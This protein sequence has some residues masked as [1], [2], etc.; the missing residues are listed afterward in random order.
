MEESV[1][2]YENPAN[3][4]SHC[5]KTARNHGFGVFG[6]RDNARCVG[7]V[8]AKLLYMKYGPSGKCVNGTGGPNAV[9]FYSFEG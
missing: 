8:H 1:T 5:Q 6:V 2:N 9:D 7:S 4:L 3:L